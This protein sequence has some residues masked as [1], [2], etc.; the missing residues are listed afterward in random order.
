MCP[1]MTCIQ[2]KFS[3]HRSYALQKFSH[4]TGSV[5]REVL[6]TIVAKAL[7]STL[8]SYSQGLIPIFPFMNYPM[9]LLIHQSLFILTNE[10]SQ[11]PLLKTKR[12]L[13]NISKQTNNWMKSMRSLKY[14]IDNEHE[15]T[16]LKS[17]FQETAQVNRTDFY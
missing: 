13:P 12:M 14:V 2:V 17:V 11:F 3:K 6:G 8:I 1:E 9:F 7:G 10:Q 15:C 5:L 16:H 4:S